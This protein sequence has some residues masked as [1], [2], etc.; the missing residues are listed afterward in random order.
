MKSVVAFLC[1]LLMCTLPVFAAGEGTDPASADEVCLIGHKGYSSLY[2][3]NTAEAFRKAGEA[4][5]PGAETDMR[6]TLDGVCV[7]SHDAEAEFEDGSRLRIAT[8]TYKQLTKKPLKNDCTESKLYL[9][10]FAEY[11]DICKEFNMI[12]FVEL[13]GVWL[14]GSIIAAFRLARERYDLS[15]VE[16]QSFELP[17]LLIARLA[18]PELRIMMACTKDGF[19]A[20]VARWL[21]FDLDMREN[22]LTK[23]IVDRFHEKGLRVSC[24]TVNEREDYERCVACGVDYIETDELTPQLCRSFTKGVSA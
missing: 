5:F 20:K 6:L 2:E 23:E 11:L 15:R 18:F 17:N 10:S 16:F 3:G 19:N 13:K 4:G 8:H 22:K 9:C 12:C 14:P 7:L 21:G 24:F 1:V